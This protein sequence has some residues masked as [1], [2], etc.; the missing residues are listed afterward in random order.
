MGYF[1]RLLI[2]LLFAMAL[3]VLP[4][5]AVAVTVSL[6][7]I[8][9]VLSVVVILISILNLWLKLDSFFEDCNESIPEP[10]VYQ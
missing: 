10:D 9:A 5:F 1:R 4:C 2:G 3:I 8:C 6:M 7:G